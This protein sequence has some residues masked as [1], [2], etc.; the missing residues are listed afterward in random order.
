VGDAGFIFET[1]K[2]KSLGSPWTLAAYDHSSNVNILSIS[3]VRQ[4]ACQRHVVKSLANESH[5]MATCGHAGGGK[6]RIET[7]KGI[8]GSKGQ[9]S[10]GIGSETRQIPR[11]M[12]C[13]NF[14][15]SVPAMFDQAVECSYASQYAKC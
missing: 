6:I 12:R 9:G 1:D 5:G 8:H 15:E 2:D 13:F 3:R 4:I 10:S 11:P 7:L 14:P